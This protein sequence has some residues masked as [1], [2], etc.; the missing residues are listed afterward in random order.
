MARVLLTT[1]GSLG[2]L[3]PYIALALELNR[4]GHE[5]MIGTSATYAEKIRAGDRISGDPP[6][7]AGPPGGPGVHEADH[8]PAE[9]AGTGHPRVHDAGAPRNV[10]GHIGRGGRRRP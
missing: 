5:A 3:H 9:G 2:D 7:Q 10:R 1:F 4:R 8:G 6:G